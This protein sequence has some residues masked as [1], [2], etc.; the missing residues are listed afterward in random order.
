VLVCIGH[1]YSQDPK[2]VPQ[3]IYISGNDGFYSEMI[4]LAGGENA[5]GGSIPNPAVSFES[6][7]SMNP[8]IIIDILPPANASIDGE[9]IKKQWQNLSNI[10][11][12]KN[13]RIY[14][15]A[16]AYMS[17]PGPRFINIIEKIAEVIKPF[18]QSKEDERKNN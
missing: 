12:I 8:Q 1:D 16:E 10:D 13:N 2:A 11:A 4:K 17:I 3:N 5:Y 15:F 6:I 18:T 14:V 9:I 7:I